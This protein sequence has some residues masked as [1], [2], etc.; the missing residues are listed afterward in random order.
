MVLL[1]LGQG[2]A[3]D[4]TVVV[5]RSDHGLGPGFDYQTKIVLC[6]FIEEDRRV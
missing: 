4:L 5:G 6:N 3:Q 1:L 2:G